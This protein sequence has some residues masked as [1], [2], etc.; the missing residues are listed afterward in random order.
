MKSPK[1][2]TGKAKKGTFRRLIKEL[3]SS[4]KWPIII[5]MIFIIVAAVSNFTSSIFVKNIT[6]AIETSLRTG[7]DPWV[8]LVPILIEVGIIYIAGLIGSFVWNLTMGITT[9]KFLNYLRKKVFDHMETLPIKYFDTHAHGDIM[10]VYTNDIDTIRQLISQSLPTLFQASFTIIAL[11]IIM[12]SFSIWL[13]IIVILGTV[14]MFLNTKLIGGKSAKYFMKQQMAMGQVEGNIEETIDGLKVIKVFCHEDKSIEDFKKINDELCHVATEGN[15]NANIVGPIMSNIGNLMYV[16]LAV[17]GG[18]LVVYGGDIPNLTILGFESQG[19]QVPVVLSF[20]MMA[21]MFSN[22]V[23]NLAQQI[24]FIAMGL[25]GASRVFDVLDEESEVDEG[26][27]TL[28]N[29]KYNEDGSFVETSERTRDYAWKHPHEDG[30]TTYTELKGDIVLDTVD[31]GYVEDKLVLT[32]ISIYARPGQQIALVGSTGAGK[33]TI[34]NLINRFYDIADGKIRY[35]GININKIKKDDLRKSLGIVL[36]ETNLF[37]GTV[38]ENIRYG[39]LNAT[40]EEVIEASKIANAYDFIMRLPQGFN[41]MLTGGGDNLSQGQR[42][43]IS[44]ARAAVA[45]TPVMILDEATSSIDTRTEK[46]VQKGTDKLMEG[47][48][49]FVIAHRLSTIMN[50]DAIMVLEHGH[51]IER[52]NH[53]ELIK[54]KGKYYQLYTGL[55]E[56]E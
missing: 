29:I 14:F 33:T 8:Q 53:D 37:T 36:Q 46:L 31:F 2:K 23:N 47:R 4:Y 26:Y 39:R 49:V 55:F 30:T 40:D 1:G 15:M 51:I 25:A 6:S 50:S 48:T 35:D 13:M 27:V 44:I 7:T 3:F 45:D 41:T 24:A 10:S 42:Q 20:L 22:N 28:V 5:A 32:D 12:M 16:L 56:L 9:Q 43:L 34:T 54:Q 18:L 17:I 38:M 52:G 21:K 11:L 19:L